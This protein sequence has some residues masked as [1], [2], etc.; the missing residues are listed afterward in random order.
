MDIQKLIIAQ[1]EKRVQKDIK[2]FM[3]DTFGERLAFPM[4]L[5]FLTIDEIRKA[6][7]TGEY[8]LL[9]ALKNG[10]INEAAMKRM[11]PVYIERETEE[12]FKKVNQLKLED[13]EEL[14]REEFCKSVDKK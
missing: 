11:L 4:I 5:E 3:S 12:F 10:W 1:A 2:T 9:E 8:S 6:E 7:I 13:L 14:H